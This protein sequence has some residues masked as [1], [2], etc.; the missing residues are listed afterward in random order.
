MTTEQRKKVTRTAMKDE[1]TM[2]VG[3]DTHQALLQHM[4]DV[5]SERLKLLLLSTT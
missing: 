3:R 1:I 2:M 5:D 4:G